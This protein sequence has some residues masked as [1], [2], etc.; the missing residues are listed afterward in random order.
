VAWRLVDLI[1]RQPVIDAAAVSREL[2][3]GANNA[4]RAIV[5]LVEAGVLKEFT[6]YQRQRIWQAT[7]VL[8]AL[9]AFA[10]RAGRGESAARSARC[11][12]QLLAGG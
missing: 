8:S 12:H 11:R 5:P 9:D 1:L 2:P 3:I 7:E 6:G 4:M 10:A